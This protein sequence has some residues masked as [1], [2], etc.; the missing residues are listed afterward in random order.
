M[1][2]REALNLAVRDQSVPVAAGQS[3][4]E[5][6]REIGV[7]AIE[8]MVDADGLLPYVRGAEGTPLSVG[9]SAAIGELKQCLARE[10]MRVCALLV[11]T[12]F[13]GDDADRH[14][15]W[16]AQV[17]EAARELAAPVVR[18]DTFT[19]NK[20]LSPPQVQENLI[21][22]IRRLL[23][24]TAESG[25]DLGMENHGPISNDPEFLDGVLSAVPDPRL[26]LTLDSGNFY[27]FGHPRG[28]V[29]R[30][31]EKYAP[32]TKH[33]H[34]KNINYPAALADRRREIGQDYKQYC[35]PLHEGSLD[36]KRVMDILRRAGYRRDFCIEDES[37][38]KMAE[39]ERIMVLRR[40]VEALR[41]ALG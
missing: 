22:R 38:F 1:M 7:R 11:A 16:A 27:W 36:L 28:D 3:L 14:V 30:L 25:V 23:Q 37:L 34:L 40:E 2:N 33:T 17:V 12:D 4:F 26:G 29:Y 41:Q 6:L 24:Q 21:R 20:S 31:I 19:A 9:D 18:I 13:S 5:V 39:H 8:A 35:C 10:G 15:E 32:R